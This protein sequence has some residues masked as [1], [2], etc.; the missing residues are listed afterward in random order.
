MGRGSGCLIPRSLFYSNTKNRRRGGAPAYFT[1]H[2]LSRLPLKYEEFVADEIPYK[3]NDGSGRL[4][5]DGPRSLFNSEDIADFVY[6]IG[7]ECVNDESGDGD[8][9][10]LEELFSYFCF[11]GTSLSERPEFVPDVAVDNCNG[12]RYHIE[13]NDSGTLG[14]SGH[15]DEETE[16]AEVNNEVC[17]ADESEFGEL[18]EESDFWV[19]SGQNVSGCDAKNASDCEYEGEYRA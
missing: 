8:G 16:D 9:D 12:N 6:G 5:D 2:S 10:K 15:P 1:T 3:D 11:V 14:Y 18:E 4:G 19:E 7:D 13:E 17:R